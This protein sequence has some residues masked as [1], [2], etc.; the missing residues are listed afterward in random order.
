MKAAGDAIRKFDEHLIWRVMLG[1]DS[2]VIHIE[3]PGGVV[4]AGK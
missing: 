2:T 4:W 3:S 1:P